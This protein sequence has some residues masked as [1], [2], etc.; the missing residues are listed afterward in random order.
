MADRFCPQCGAAL[1]GSVHFCLRCG[2]M[3]GDDAAPSPPQ[4]SPAAMPSAPQ[5]FPAARPTP[6]QPPS[7]IQRSAP[8][9]P[10]GFGRGAR[11]ALVVG[12]AALAAVFGLLALGQRR[13]AASRAGL[14]PSPAAPLEERAPRTYETPRPAP[15]PAPREETRERAPSPEGAEEGGPVRAVVASSSLPDWRG[16]SFRPELAF[17]GR[18]DTSWQPLRPGVGAWIR[19]DFRR[20]VVVEGLEVANGFQREDDLGDLFVQ[21]ARVARA[22]VNLCGRE[23]GPIA[24]EFDPGRRGFSRFAFPPTKTDCLTF[25]VDEISPGTRWPDVAVSELRVL[26]RE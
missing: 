5:P 12:A 13:A 25:V 19:V 14:P 1:P 15:E 11:I 4:P 3:Y 26:G 8:E 24:L 16:Y 22:H 9:R 2:A 18:L 23:D 6:P 17:D 10:R 20:P 21:N 7:A